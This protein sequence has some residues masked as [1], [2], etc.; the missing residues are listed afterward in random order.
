MP[1]NPTTHARRHIAALGLLV[2]T[3]LACGEDAA[4]SSGGG[5]L[6]PET[7]GTSNTSGAETCGAL[8]VAA[9]QTPQEDEGATECPGKVVT[10]DGSCLVTEPTPPKAVAPQRWRCPEG[11]SPLTALEAREDPSDLDEE[12]RALLSDTSLCAPPPPPEACPPGSMAVLGQPECQP[13]GAPCPTDALW[14]EEPALRQRLEASPT[15]FDGAVRYVSPDADPDGA[16]GTRALPF[17]TVASALA[18]SDDGDIVAVGVGEYA[19]EVLVER[20]VALVGACVEHTTLTAPTRDESLATVRVA[21]PEG[22]WLSDLT[23]T[24]DRPG[25]QVASNSGG[26]QIRG[27]HLRATLGEGIAVVGAADVRISDTLFSE[28]RV[29]RSTGDGLQ[30]TVTRGGAARGERLTFEGNRFASVFAEGQ[31]TEVTLTDTLI[32]DTQPR[33][34]GAQGIGVA[35]LG[36]ASLEGERLLLTHN[37]KT[38]ALLQGAGTQGVFTDTIIADTQ[39]RS[40]DMQLGRGLNALA[41]AS[42]EGERVWL[43]RNHDYGAIIDAATATLTDLVVTDTQPDR[44]QRLAG[45]GV[46]VVRGG[47][48]TLTRAL[49]D[50]SHAVGVGVEDDGSQA[51]LT[52]LVI[53]DTQPQANTGLFGRGLNA[54]ERGSVRV[55]RAIIDLNHEL[56]VLVS[57][58]GAS[59]ALSDVVV[60]RTRPLQTD[61]TLGG[62]LL[63]TRSATASLTRARVERNHAVGVGV[64]RLNAQATLTDVALIGTW[65]QQ[66]DQTR[67][68]GLDVTETAHVEGERLLI[69]GNHD[70][71]VGVASAS[72][73]AR[74]LILRDTQPTHLG[75]GAGLIAFAGAEVS[76]ARVVATGN[77]AL[78]LGVEDE[79]S[80]LTLSDAAILDTQPQPANMTLGRGLNAGQGGE[81]RGE[82]L[83]LDR[84]HEVGLFVGNPGSTA[85]LTDVT[86]RRTLPSAGRGA[87]GTGA[88]VTQGGE[89]F[90]ERLLV[91]GN[92]TIGLLVARDG[93][94]A[95]LTD[96][97]IEGTAQGTFNGWEG[98]VGILAAFQG[99]LS[100]ERFHVTDNALTG[101][102]VAD[103]AVQ[104]AHGEVRGNFAGLSID[105]DEFDPSRDLGCVEFK[106]N[107]CGASCAEQVCNVEYV[108]LPIPEAIDAFEATRD[109]DAR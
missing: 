12:S 55:E 79:G 11:W 100:L 25:V 33:S 85:H 82:R 98:G 5:L 71:G 37:H 17:P 20:R 95:T 62:G 44:R 3:G 107:C 67:G 51:T 49:V 74:D 36:G 35:A 13:I 57:G 76:V 27:A 69:A 61:M 103:A 101:I 86:I 52:D 81:L 94:Q 109:P 10:E 39:P 64:E 29:R 40:A 43:A 90:G 97:R 4:K 66:S 28:G 83:L 65:P 21:S 32:R 56:G 78:G 45:L 31:G 58:E 34:D 9:P 88:V 1:R 87:L 105:S 96:L 8:T 15:P 54:I 22:A 59:G 80:R 14:P 41:G 42:V 75:S 7:S 30:L 2:L 92:R 60:R 68:R 6:S 26:V 38:G 19:E 53:H 89:M 73:T 24:G 47:A 104:G 63:V 16:D 48:A 72:L 102:H 93:S 70:L 99:R 108:D 77:H 46:I 50:R 91:Q 23:V 18:A 106:D 84:N